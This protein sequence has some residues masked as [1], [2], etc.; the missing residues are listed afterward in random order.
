MKLKNLISPVIHKLILEQI[1]LEATGQDFYN[2]LSNPNFKYEDKFKIEVP[3]SWLHPEDT[4]GY[5]TSIELK[6]PV[7]MSMINRYI[8]TYVMANVELKKKFDKFAYWYN[9]FNKLIF[10]SLSESDACLFLSACAFCS[11][12]TAL[13]Q[14][15][16]EAAKLFSAVKKD[17]LGGNKELL[18]QFAL[19]VKDNVSEKSLNKIKSY[20]EKG[21]AYAA[22]LAPK[23]L[24]GQIAQSGPYKGKNDVFSEITVSNAKI[25]NF[26]KFVIYYL[27]NEGNVRRDQLVGEL[28]SGNYDIGGTK[29]FSFFINLIDPDYKWSVD[30]NEH[31]ITPATI[32]RWMIRVFFY[33]PLKEI[34]DIIGD[35]AILKYT[36]PKTKPTKD[37]PNKYFDK[38]KSLQSDVKDKVINKIIMTLFSTDEVRQNLVKLL[39]D[40]AKQAGL[41]SQQ[42]QALAWVQ[43]REEFGEP[44]AKF[45]NFEDVMNYATKTI[46]EM[47]KDLDFLKEINVDS[48]YGKFNEAIRTINILANTP[49][50]KFKDASD[51]EF[52]VKNRNDYVK[53]YKFPQKDKKIQA[54][55]EDFRVYTKIRLGINDDNNSADIFI[56][57]VKPVTN[58]KGQT[59]TT[60]VPKLLKT[61]QGNG[62][63]ELI[64]NAFRWI[65]DNI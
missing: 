30:N 51:V 64:N 45:G 48:L 40:I 16:L 26:N 43:V 37:E 54:Q 27:D 46:D 13:D 25:P 44:A 50:F 17:F 31:G 34:L 58:K 21:S 28:K 3:V 52:S 2:Q 63:K 36:E 41:S 47:D 19:D 1:Y 18:R 33:N 35:S 59:K 6:V 57:E 61:V 8:N 14:N 49:R 5:D 4:K 15:I 62:R 65:K 23:W 56:D 9:N 38:A 7:D 29:I 12:N 11:A 55:V 10:N 39:N 60:I 32:D 24:P 42:L 22:M 53:V 20:V